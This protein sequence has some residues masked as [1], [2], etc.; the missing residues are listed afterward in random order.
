M[1]LEPEFSSGF[2]IFMIYHHVPTNEK[3][4]SQ[5]KIHQTKIV[6]Y[7]REYLKGSDRSWKWSWSLVIGHLLHFD[8]LQPCT[9]LSQKFHVWSSLYENWNILLR[10]F[11]RVRLVLKLEFLV[12]FCIVTILNH[13]LTYHENVKSEVHY[14]KIGLF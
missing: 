9:Y 6:L 14:M 12:G 3:Q 4:R 7:Y 13:L 10:I 11:E 5:R 8:D 2:W 1:V